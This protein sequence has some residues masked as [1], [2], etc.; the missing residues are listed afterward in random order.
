MDKILVIDNSLYFTGAFKSINFYTE[1][2]K[3]DFKF[4]Y[5]IP[6]HSSI[7][8]ILLR[9][10]YELKR[11][12]FLEIQK[13][14]KILFYLPLLIINSLKLSHFVRS[15]N[16]R[17]VHVNDLYNMTGVIVKLLVPRVKLVYHIRLLPTSY[18]GKFFRIWSK[19]ISWKADKILCV[20]SAVYKAFPSSNKKEILIDF[21]QLEEKYK[22]SFPRVRNEVVKILY[23]GNLIQGKGQ[24]IAIKAFHSSFLKNNNLRIKFI[25]K[26]IDLNYKSNIETYVENNNLTGFVT[27]QDFNGE[28]EM[29]I[30]SSDIVLNLSLSES[31]SFVCYE[32]LFYG[33]ALISSDSGGPFDLIINNH[34]GFLIPVNNIE[35]ASDAILLLSEN[36]KLRQQ[37]VVNGK[38]LLEDRM[39]S[40]SSEEKLK[41]IYDLL[42]RPL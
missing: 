39:K 28:I 22:N 16:I 36:L 9:Q 5:C 26:T 27:I 8:G 24:D 20:S 2:L 30:K 31:F 1:S 40:Q 42:H 34:N 17:V 6:Q 12:N 4:F 29:E 25:G 41:N 11:I 37:F 14:L 19:V 35:A 13:N 3:K 21:I 32:A 15:K 18:I 38:K 23:I 7:E 10:G 33:T